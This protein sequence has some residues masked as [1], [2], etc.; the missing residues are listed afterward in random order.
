M[1]DIRIPVRPTSSEPRPAKPRKTHNFSYAGFG[2]IPHKIIVANNAGGGF[3]VPAKM[4][5]Y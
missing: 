3:K 1:I 2:S 4:P 5:K